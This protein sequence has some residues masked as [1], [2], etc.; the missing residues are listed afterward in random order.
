MFWYGVERRSREE[1]WPGMEDCRV[2]LNM[3]YNGWC[4]ELSWIGSVSYL[5]PFSLAGGESS[6]LRAMYSHVPALRI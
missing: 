4:Y 6:Y 1:T 2:V 3:V 5:Q